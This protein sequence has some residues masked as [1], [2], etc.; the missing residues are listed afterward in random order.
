MQP[1]QDNTNLYFIFLLKFKE[2]M[3]DKKTIS[4][5]AFFT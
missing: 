3:T 5:N 2:T 1:K 4:F